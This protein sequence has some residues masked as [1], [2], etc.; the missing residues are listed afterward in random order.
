MLLHLDPDQTLSSPPT[1][2]LTTSKP[3]PK[4]TLAIGAEQTPFE[5]AGCDK[6]PTKPDP[7]PNRTHALGAEQAPFEVAGFN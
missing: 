6:Y 2:T 3:N 4:N 1:K 5:V 7:N